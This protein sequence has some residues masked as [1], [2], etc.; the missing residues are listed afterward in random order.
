MGAPQGQQR[1]GLRLAVVEIHEWSRPTLIDQRSEGLEF[2]VTHLVIVPQHVEPALQNRTE[3][4]PLS[5]R[6]RA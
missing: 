4:C 3:D 2:R 5:T 6:A 1:S